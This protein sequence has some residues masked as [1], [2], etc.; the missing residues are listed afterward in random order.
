MFCSIK[1][2][3]QLYI[4]CKLSKNIRKK[5]VKLMFAKIYFQILHWFDS[6]KSQDSEELG[7]TNNIS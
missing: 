1:S 3:Q 5:Y 7:V 2:A 4:L 6:L